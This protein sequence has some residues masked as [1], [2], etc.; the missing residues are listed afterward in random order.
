MNW[1]APNYLLL[2]LVIPLMLIL[3]SSAKVWQKKRFSKF[4]DQRFFKF[5][6]AQ[7]S[8][9]HW[10]LKN[11]LII[12]ASLFLI[13]AAARPRWGQEMQIVTKEGLDIVICIDVSKSME[14]TDI[15][16]NRLQRAKDHISLFID[17]LRGDRIA[18][19][20][21]AGESFVQLPLTDDYAAAKMFLSLLDTDTIPVSGTNIA[22]ALET[23]SNLFQ[24]PDKE[25]IIILISDGED[26]EGQ[27]ISQ[28]EKIADQGI[29]IHALG[30]GSTEGS[31]IPI[32][33]AQGNIEYAKDGAGNVVISK[34]D[35]TTLNR[36]AQV[37]G[38]RF[39]HVTPHRA[40]IFEI[41]RDIEALERE[42]YEAREYVRYRERYHYF[43]FFALFLL[44]LEVLIL[45]K[46]NIPQE[47][48]L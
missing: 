13:L 20:P 22:Y 32:R 5:Y 39:Y 24:E 34:L 4:A 7:F 44:F 9:F 16:P 15:R 17:Q 18:L 3:L 10:S 12:I 25:R 47:R 21:F 33:T 28:A 1:A 48:N 36:I 35:A 40:E 19:V 31:P 11:L 42:K 29:V 41:L 6:L 8:H 27:G 43:A 37:T 23:A 2:L 45:Y 26:L 46:K 14:A 38:G 30:V